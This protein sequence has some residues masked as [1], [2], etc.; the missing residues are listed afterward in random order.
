MKYATNRSNINSLIVLLAC[1]LLFIGIGRI[2]SLAMYN[3]V[4]GYANNYDMIRLQACHQIWSADTI[5]DITAGTPTAPLRR[6]T[7]DKRVETPCFPS[8]ELLFTHSGIELGKLKNLATGEV[9]ISIK[10]IG[11]VKAIFLAVTAIFASLFFYRSQLYGAMLANGLVMLLV[12]SDP[13]ITLYMNTFYTEF[14]AVYFLYLALIGVVV[15]AA[16]Q[17]KLIHSAPLL[18]GLLGLGFSK[19][20]HMPLALC[21]GLLLATFALVIQRQWKIIPALL[22]C[23]L[24]PLLLQTSGY[25]EPRNESMVRVNKVNLVGSMLGITNNPERVLTDLTLPD[26]CKILAGRNGYDPEIQ[27]SNICPELKKIGNGTITLALIKNPLL[28]AKLVQIA[29]EQQKN[30]VFDMYGQVEHGRTESAGHYQRTISS[31]VQALPNSMLVLLP[32]IATLAVIMLLI[33]GRYRSGVLRQEH[34]YLLMLIATQAVIVV[35]AILEGGSVGAAKSIHLFFPLLLSQFI[36]LPTIG[37]AVFWTK[38]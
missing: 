35:S 38:Q 6:Y 36:F 5:I 31:F 24:M 32:F 23:S 10:T 26:S 28:L 12:L 1:L 18:I 34:L 37:S 2:F 4:L 27:K 20:Q 7:L 9:L 19:P 8:S 21:M 30:W 3:P 17:W 14:S 22:L 33:G 16:G 25:F 13:G 15:T 29:L 11:L